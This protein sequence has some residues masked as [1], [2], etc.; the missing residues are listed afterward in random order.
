MLASGSGPS[1]VV[2]FGFDAELDSSTSWGKD[3]LFPLPFPER[4]DDGKSGDEAGGS[5]LDIGMLEGVAGEERNVVLGGCDV[6]G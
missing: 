2:R 3:T 5:P 4:G 1:S 6:G